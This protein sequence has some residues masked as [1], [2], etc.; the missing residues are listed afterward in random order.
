MSITY[1]DFP[2][3][4]GSRICV[5]HHKDLATMPHIRLDG[6]IS[7]HAHEFYEMV[8]VIENSCRHIYQDDVTTLLPGDLFL[9]P[10]HQPHAYQFDEETEYYNCQ[11]YIDMISARWIED[12]HELTY[13][14]LRESGSRGSAPENY[15]TNRR[16][17]LH[18]SPED[19]AVTAVFFDKILMEQEHPRPDSERMKQSIL[20][21][22]LAGINRVRLRS[23]AISDNE[24]KWKQQMISDVLGR[25]QG[26]ISTEWDL[27]EIAAEYH[28][29]SSYFRSIF[30][31]ITGMPPRQYINKI[32]INRAVDM[33]QHQGLSL[34]DASAAAGIYDLNY[35]SRLC[36]QFT[37]YSPSYFRRK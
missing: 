23:F 26:E 8:L 11:F 1:Y 31:K 34:A 14:R 19:T 17:I 7:F 2:L 30:K 25:F 4:D 29:S 3:T 20:H 18:M 5:Q 28:I 22:V 6:S 32:R 37:G 10:P 16:G 13:D 12:I 9:I 27:D 36:K 33:I 21:L 15:G 35:F 24:E